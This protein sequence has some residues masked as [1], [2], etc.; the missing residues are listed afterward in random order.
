MKNLQQT[1]AGRQRWHSLDFISISKYLIWRNVFVF[2]QSTSWISEWHTKQ[3]CQPRVVSLNTRVWHVICLY[4]QYK[5]LWMFMIF[6]KVSWHDLVVFKCG[7]ISVSSCNERLLLWITY[8]H[9]AFLQF[10]QFCSKYTLLY[11]RISPCVHTH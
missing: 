10:A 7:M 6:I 8:F 4:V 2:S 5:Y 11:I 1:N 3:I 9:S